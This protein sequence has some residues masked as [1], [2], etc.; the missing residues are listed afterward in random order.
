MKVCLVVGHFF[1][2]IGGVEKLFLDF[3]KGIQNAGHEV[4]VITSNSGGVTG[5]NEFEGID[6]YYYPWKIFCGHPIPRIRDLEEHI[7]WADMV[8][9]TTFTVANPTRKIAK[10][11]KKPVV[12]TIHEV[13]GN[14]WFW[15]EKNPLK[16]LIFKL[17]EKQVC[18]KNY[19]FIHV[20]SEATK[21]DYIKYYGNRENIEC[22]YLSVDGDVKQL[23]QTSSFNVYNYFNI[24]CK[25][26]IVLY[27]GRPG[28]SK[29]IFVYLE[30][31][32]ILKEKYD[33]TKLKDVQFCFLLANDPLK[34]K[35]KF[36]KGI[37]KYELEEIVKVQDSVKRRDLFKCINDAEM[38]VVPSITE[39]F[40]LCAA[41]TCV[42][43]KKIVYSDGGSLPEVVSGRCLGFEN[44]NSEDLADKLYNALIKEEI[45]NNIPKKE[46]T[47]EMM[48]TRLLEVYDTLLKGIDKI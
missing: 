24:D 41:E 30:A 14:K 20:D 3:A 37:K 9:T 12:V 43:E 23:A 27:F 36:L 33:I 44:R 11:L 21:K 17:Y 35:L 5:R 7:K 29:G 39:G 4:R 31:L 22:I 26:K 1:P 6:T 28:Q 19:D 32:H 8:H 40:G 25:N 10:K 18:C 16:A 13:L 48:I 42:L 45:F 46:F 34:Q 15:V 2:H 47:L 38:V